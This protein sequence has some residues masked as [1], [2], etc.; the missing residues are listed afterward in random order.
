MHTGSHGVH[1]V[2]AEVRAQQEPKTAVTSRRW[3]KLLASLEYE[4]RL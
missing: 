3:Y 2:T 4:V 1:E